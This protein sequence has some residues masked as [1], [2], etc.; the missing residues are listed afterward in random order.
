MERSSRS[1]KHLVML[2]IQYLVYET[3]L[4]PPKRN[5]RL[6]NVTNSYV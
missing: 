5:E 3:H 6:P 2:K 1:N 4:M